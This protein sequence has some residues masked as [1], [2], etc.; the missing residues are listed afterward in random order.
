M[1][2]VDYQN[3]R[4][5]FEGEDEDVFALLKFGY[6]SPGAFDLLVKILTQAI[7]YDALAPAVNGYTPGRMDIHIDL[8]SHTS[9]FAGRE[10]NNL[11]LPTELNP[12]PPFIERLRTF[13]SHTVQD[14]SLGYVG[15]AE[16]YDGILYDESE[17]DMPPNLM[18]SQIKG[19]TSHYLIL[20]IDHPAWL[21]PSSTPGHSHLFIDKKVKS[22]A[23]KDIIESLHSGGLLADGNMRQL[24]AYGSQFLRLPGVKKSKSIKES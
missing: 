14:Q 21:V 12:Y 1:I 20:D 2:S 6:G 4:H 13:F 22:E 5:L 18:S 3:V 16:D 11:N 23:F 10:F 19:S 24:Y 17:T 15:D 7:P 8:D 9:N